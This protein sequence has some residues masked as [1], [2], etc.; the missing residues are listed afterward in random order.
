M[1]NLDGKQVAFGK[2]VSGL[3][4]IERIEACGT[5]DGTPSKRVTIVDCGE[6]EQKGAKVKRLKTEKTSAAGIVQVL[7]ILRK[8][9]GCKKPSSWREATITCTKEDAANYLVGL[10]SKLAEVK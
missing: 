7:H 3:E 1:P 5:E 6:V 2:V 8:H 10:R 4:I 9:T